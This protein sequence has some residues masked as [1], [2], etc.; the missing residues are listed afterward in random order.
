M[1]Y[2]AEGRVVRLIGNTMS[3]NERKQLGDVLAQTE[4]RFRAAFENASDAMVMSDP[5]GVVVTANHAYFQLYGYPAEEVIGHPF[6]I[7]F[8]EAFRQ[9]ARDEYRR[10]FNHPDQLPFSESTVL[11]KDGTRHIV[12][13]RPSFVMQDGQRMYMLSIIRDLTERKQA[14]RELYARYQLTADL[15]DAVTVEDVGRITVEHIINYQGADS[16]NIYVYQAADNTFKRLYDNRDLSPQDRQRWHSFPVDPIFPITHVMQHNEALWFSS[17]EE[18]EAAYPATVIFER[19]GALVLL[20]L[21]VASQVFGVIG[22]TFLEPRNFSESERAF[23]N[24]LVFQCAQAIQRARLAEN[25]REL[26]VMHERQRLARDL[27]DNVNQLLFS[28]SVLSEMLPRLIVN[29]PEKAVQQ[30]EQVNLMLRGAMAEMRTL[31]WELRPEN[32]VQTHLSSLLTQ[33]SHAIRARQEAEISVTLH[34]PHEYLL[35]PDPQVTFYRVAQES[36]HNVVKHGQATVV[37]I[38]M[39]QTE[40]YTALIVS[41]NGHGFDSQA[42]GAGF[43]LRNMR[44]R[45]EL[46]NAQFDIKSQIGKGTRVRLLWK[47]PPESESPKT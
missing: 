40:R 25:A 33:L 12:E 41:D 45:A 37:S 29:K 47:S 34:V 10:V 4:A 24:S 35:P 19:L 11:H 26:A 1:I 3:I 28:S 6:E 17:V 15:T 2:D 9:I 21:T 42:E 23:M 5:D 31:L 8:P 39:R 32:I 44:E 27:H 16:G 46:I 20:P 30:A 13:S 38:I 36:V 18:R 22:I 14:E 7:I 43:G